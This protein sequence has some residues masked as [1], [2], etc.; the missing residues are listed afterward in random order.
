MLS[1]LPSSHLFK[2][3]SSDGA[4]I[5]HSNLSNAIN[6]PSID[7]LERIY[8]VGRVLYPHKAVIAAGPPP[9][10]TPSTTSASTTRNVSTKTTLLLES[11]PVYHTI[12]SCQAPLE[13]VFLDLG[14]VKTSFK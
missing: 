12:I 4:E 1:K 9:L 5:C 7:G 2:R 6:L 8:V 3:A 14:I 10:N 13:N 11:S